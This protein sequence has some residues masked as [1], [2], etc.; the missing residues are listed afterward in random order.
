MD[1]M[2]LWSS[3]RKGAD[4]EEI[5]SLYQECPLHEKAEGYGDVNLLH[6]ASQ[7]AHPEA[8]NDMLETAYKLA[9]RA[10]AKKISALLNGTYSPDEEQSPEAQ[11]KIATGGMTLHEAVLPEPERGGRGAA[12]RRRGGINYFCFPLVILRG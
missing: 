10:G 11:A 1:I 3:Y 9:M 4:P 2:E 8:E 6:I 7:N 12:H 5:F